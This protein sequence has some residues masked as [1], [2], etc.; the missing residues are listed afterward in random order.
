MPFQASVTIKILLLRSTCS[1]SKNTQFR[2]ENKTEAEAEAPPRLSRFSRQFLGQRYYRTT[3]D[4]RFDIAAEASNL[5][6][7]S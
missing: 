3:R 6:Y 4:K 5:F 7:D 1:T 2:T